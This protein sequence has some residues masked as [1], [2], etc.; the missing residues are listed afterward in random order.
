MAK[1]KRPPL[2]GNQSSFWDRKTRLLTFALF[3]LALGLLL[4]SMRKKPQPV[5]ATPTDDSE[6][7]QESRPP[8][9]LHASN[10]SSPPP[11]ASALA[12]P[13]PP[14]VIDEIDLEKNEVCAG[15]ENLVT[16]KA[17]TV[18]GT[19][20]F[21]HMVIDG[22]MGS[23]V[24]V[25]LWTDA[26]GKV[27]GK[28]IVEVFGRNNVHTFVP[29][30]KY[31][32]KDCRATY[33]AAVNQRIRSNTWADFDFQARLIA[34][35]PGPMNE[36]QA[37]ELRRTGA[38]PPKAAPLWKPVSFAWNFGDGETDTTTNP[39]TEHNYEGRKQDAL[40][41]YFLVELTIRG[42]KPGETATGRTMLALINPAFEALAQKGAV[43]LLISLDPRFP[44]LGPDGIVHQN[45]K[46]WHNQPGPVTINKA[47]LTTY[48]KQAAGEAPPQLVDVASVLG[49][50]VIPA[51]K[52]GITATVTLDPESDVE[53]FSKTWNLEGKSEEGYPAYGA[54][55]VMLPVPK[56]TPDAS[57]PV[58][59]PMLTKKIILARQLLG[60]DV[61]TDEDLWSL[62]RQGAFASLTVSPE[63]AAAAKQGGAAA[64]IANGKGPPLAYNPPVTPAPKSAGEQLAT[65]NQGVVVVSGQQGASPG[66]GK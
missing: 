35:P 7:A 61:V 4:W 29:L 43:Q 14:P 62:E 44:E 22:H 50:N 36:A 59:D 64:A 6:Q 57:T 33:L 38:P 9:D 41:S 24:P 1:R 42:A 30:P 31:T 5:A 45:V 12:V 18:N 11:G 63:E 54:F 47:I 53:V 37:M 49:T 39:I 46:I 16:V 60:K 40:Y 8:G 48:Y 56:P 20:P 17:H 23:A 65:P 55:S 66:G 28:H 21:L 2:R 19:D 32:V 58:A 13:D 51:G 27:M 3:G 26:N 25:Q 34:V 10:P 15:E 52:D